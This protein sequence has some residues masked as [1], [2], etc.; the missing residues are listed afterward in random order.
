MVLGYGTGSCQENEGKFLS[1]KCSRNFVLFD[2]RKIEETKVFVYVLIVT[3]QTE[4]LSSN[5]I[6]CDLLGTGTYQPHRTA[7]REKW[8]MGFEKWEQET[9]QV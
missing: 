7:K 3:L 6:S 1:H 2:S 9:G 8:P 4:N 5:N